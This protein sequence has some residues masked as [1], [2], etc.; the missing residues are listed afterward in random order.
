MGDDTIEV[1]FGRREERS[2]RASSVASSGRRRREESI[3]S[4]SGI[5]SLREG[6]VGKDGAGNVSLLDGF[7]GDD[8]GGDRIGLGRRGR[9][10]SLTPVP[11]DIDIGP[12]P[13]DL[14]L[15]LGDG[16]GGFGDVDDQDVQ[17]IPMDVDL[18]ALEPDA[19]P[20]AAEAQADALSRARREST[21]LTTPPAE[22]ES[23]TR[24]SFLAEMMDSQTAGRIA[25]LTAQREVAAA[26]RER[27]QQEEGAGRRKKRVRIAEIDEEIELDEGEVGRRD[28]SDIL[29]K[30]GSGFL[31]P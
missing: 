18:P 7:G 30:V 6:S 31:R 23:S 29:G 3:L 28:V 13:L 14:G 20:D 1:E 11:M 22:D 9:D 16:F 24:D 27:A 2:A 8:V 25:E 10:M 21:R 26:N 12:E 15:D 17:P 5:R 4:G 19:D